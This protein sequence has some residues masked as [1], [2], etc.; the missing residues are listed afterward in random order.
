MGKSKIHILFYLTPALLSASPSTPLVTSTRLGIGIQTTVLRMVKKKYANWKD[1]GYEWRQ[2]PLSIFVCDS[3]GR[4]FMV[5]MRML[6]CFMSYVFVHLYTSIYT[7]GVDRFFFSRVGRR[8]GGGDNSK[9]C[10]TS[11]A[12]F[13]QHLSTQSW[14]YTFM[15]NSEHFHSF[16]K[17]SG[18]QG[19]Y[20]NF[21]SPFHCHMPMYTLNHHKSPNI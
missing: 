16:H 15:L 4:R 6:A 11:H 18:T 13:A 17:Y 9:V 12:P 3:G 21:S 20:V 10:F 1:I 8:E 7:H 5:F 2:P 14:H 19:A